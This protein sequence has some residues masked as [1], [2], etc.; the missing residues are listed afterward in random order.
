MDAGA[1][2]GD[3]PAGADPLAGFDPDAAAAGEVAAA[4]GFGFEPVPGADLDFPAGGDALPACPEAALGAWLGGAL[5][6]V[7][8]GAGCDEGVAGGVTGAVAGAG[9]AAWG[10]GLD[11]GLVS[12]AHPA[13]LTS[14][15]P[16][17]TPQPAHALCRIDLLRSA[18]VCAP[19]EAILQST[20]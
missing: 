6:G 10:G 12:W 18:R 15:Q 17:S 3:P 19:E 8:S 13:R 7:G 5:A 4:G 9:A 20:T 14:A 11:A 16:S 1:A 2:G